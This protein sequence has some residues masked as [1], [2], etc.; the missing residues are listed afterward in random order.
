[1]QDISKR[2]ERAIAV[3]KRYGVSPSYFPHVFS[4]LT[5]HDETLWRDLVISISSHQRHWFK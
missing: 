5:K 4:I 3:M 2:E 1:M